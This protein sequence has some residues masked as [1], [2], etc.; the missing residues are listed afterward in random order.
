MPDRDNPVKVK[1]LARALARA[2]YDAIGLG[3]QEFRLGVDRLRELARRHDLPLVCANVRDAA[4]DRVATPNVIRNVN[5]FRVGIFS[6]IADRAWGF[7]VREWRTGLK[8]E[9]P[10][11]AARRQ[12]TELQGCDLVVA[13]L[14]MSMLDAHDLL[15]QVPG[16]DVAIVGHDPMVQRKPT[17]IGKTLVLC[18]GEAGRLLGSLTIERGRPG[19]ELKLVPELTVLSAQVSDAG[20]VMDLYW[21]YVAESKDK[22]PPDWGLAPIPP[23]Y[24]TAEACKECHEDEYA[25]WRTTKHAHAYESIKKAGRQ[26]DPECVLCHTMGLGRKGGFV[27]MAKT[28]GLGRVTCQACHPVTRDHE[29]KGVKVDPEVHISSRLCMSCH[30]PV[31]SPD[32]DYFV[33]KPKILHTSGPEK[34][35]GE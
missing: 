29:E 12:V 23:R 5:G 32:F 34:R 16:I 10:A 20:W 24:E 30:G 6:V 31:Q 22:P 28:P 8:V 27:S 3:D 4:G 25:H 17:R 33:Y 19:D 14:H 1:Y 9:P 13:L 18:P 11:H 15:T 2:K 26:K 7:P 35:T 21:Q